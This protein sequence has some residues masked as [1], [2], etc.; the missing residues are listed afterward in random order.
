VE[1]VGLAFASVLHSEEVPLSLAL[2]RIVIF[3]KEFVLEIFNFQSF[4]QVSAFESRFKNKCCVF[5]R[6]V[7]R[8]LLRLLFFAVFSLQ[9]VVRLKSLEISIQLRTAVNVSPCGISILARSLSIRG[10]LLE[11][12]GKI[13]RREEIPFLIRLIDR[14]GRLV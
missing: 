2:G 7:L 9:L 6:F 13:G 1:L 4:P 10:S 3:Q 8:C 14:V 5:H 12:V 11:I